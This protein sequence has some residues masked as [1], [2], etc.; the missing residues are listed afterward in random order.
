[1]K[2]VW[3]IFKEYYLVYTLAG[4]GL[5]ILYFITTKAQ[6]DIV[7]NS[8]IFGFVFWLLFIFFGTL[9]LLS[10]TYY[11]PW[12]IRKMLNSTPF[13]EFKRKGFVNDK[14]N[15]LKGS[16][17]GYNLFIGILWENYQKKPSYFVQILF[18]PF[19][20]ERFLRQDEYEKYEESLSEENKTFTLNSIIILN[21]RSKY[22]KKT[23][24]ESIMKDVF[25]TIDFL[26]TRKLDP[27]SFKEW[28]DNISDLEKH[29]E[30]FVY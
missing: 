19:S 3:Y 2:K 24:Y 16:I 29:V 17:R 18:N 11:R 7:L 20:N 15:D 28:F 1:M 9:E 27:I 5:F 26:K 23:K 12:K 6:D 30:T 22:L 13:I 10:H 21:E 4:I 8:F 25:E 14:E